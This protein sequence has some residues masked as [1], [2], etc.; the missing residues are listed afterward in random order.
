MNPRV[1]GT[2]QVT[3]EPLDVA[4]NDWI[5]RI[6]LPLEAYSVRWTKT[7]PYLY[8]RDEWYSVITGVKNRNSPLSFTDTTV[9]IDVQS[10]EGHGDEDNV[11]IKFPRAELVGPLAAALEHVHALG[12][13]FRDE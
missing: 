2:M 5:L 7:E 10:N 8:T 11:V 13:K 6:E 9:T 12:L 3:I 4:E 1:D